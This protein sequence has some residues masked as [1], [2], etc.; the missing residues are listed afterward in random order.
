MKYLIVGLGNIGAE[1]EG[2]RHNSGFMVADRL[3]KDLG[4]SFEL[5]RHAYR[6]EAKYKGRTLVIIKPTTYMNLSCKA[7]KYWMTTEKIQI[8]NVLVIVDDLALPVGT[9][10]LKGKGGAGGHNGL[11][12]IEQCLGTQD[13]ARLRVG[14]GDNFSR[15]KQID[16]VLG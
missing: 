1:Y 14:I 13:Y 11:T 3:A 16:Y 8:E 9:L 7:V 6:A 15:G 10:R 5:S 4:C 12:D 2:S